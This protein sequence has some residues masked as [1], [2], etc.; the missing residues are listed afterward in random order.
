MFSEIHTRFA[1]NFRALLSYAPQPYAGA[2]AFL[3][4]EDGSTDEAVAAWSQ[5][6]PSGFHYVA[7]P[8]DHYTVMQSPR[9]RLLADQLSLWL[10]GSAA[11]PLEGIQS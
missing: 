9:L 8:G 3:R 10:A 2:T 6:F 4:A 11:R 7:L 1:R 5:L